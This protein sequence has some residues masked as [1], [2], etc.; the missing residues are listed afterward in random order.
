M[1]LFAFLRLLILCLLYP[2]PSLIATSQA[3]KNTAADVRGGVHSTRPFR[4]I[5]TI[6]RCYGRMRNISCVNKDPITSCPGDVFAQGDGRSCVRV[7]VRMCRSQK[8]MVDPGPGPCHHYS[9]IIIYT[10]LRTDL[11]PAALLPGPSCDDHTAACDKLQWI[12]AK[13]AQNN[14]NP[15]KNQHLHGFPY[16]L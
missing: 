10:P 2:I 8:K 7:C 16:D 11:L 4:R 12:T 9:L 3:R 14:T 1:L 13:N 5:S 6:V 15:V